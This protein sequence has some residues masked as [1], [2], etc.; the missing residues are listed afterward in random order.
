MK[1]A[2][3]LA[4]QDTL[5]AS[6]R[7][8]A[9]ISPGAQVHEGHAAVAAIFPLWVP[10]NNAIAYDASPDSARLAADEVTPLFDDA[11][12]AT[13]ALWLS[14]S[15]NSFDAPDS[16]GSIDGF[17]RDTTTLVMH[18]ALSA[19]RPRS[20]A[21]E[22]TTIEAA[23]RATDEVVPAN[24][25]PPPDGAGGVDAWVAVVGGYAV[26]GAWS[27]LH[28]SDCG[29]Y[30]VGTAVDW[31]RRGAATALMHNVL[32]DAYERGAQS[33]TLQSTRMGEPLYTSLGFR[34]VGRYEEWVPL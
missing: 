21:V 8:L 12:V 26:A 17:T 29:I 16:V 28:G 14:S 6:W 10:L 13:W 20:S 4:G 33:A 23:G 1:L 9:T 30:A 2:L 24:E 15:A 31:R 19:A 34:A 7:A 5:I 11:R 3:P 18:C 25:L 22:R 27:Y 32:A